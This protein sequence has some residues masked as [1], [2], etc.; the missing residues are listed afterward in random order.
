MSTFEPVVS[1]SL[2]SSLCMGRNFWGWRNKL[3][4]FGRH[5][6][7]QE[8]ERWEEHTKEELEKKKKNYRQELF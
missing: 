7:E 2:S 4:I 8:E 5:H 3:G 6:V 1:V